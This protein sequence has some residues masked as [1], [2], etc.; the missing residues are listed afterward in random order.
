MG[1]W[2]KCSDQ[3][4]D[5]GKLVLVFVPH[6]FKYQQATLMFDGG[7]EGLWTDGAID[8]YQHSI[9]HWQPLPSPPEDV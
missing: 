3:M 6:D 2:I 4:P 5:V 7:D 8:Y 1:E 9:T